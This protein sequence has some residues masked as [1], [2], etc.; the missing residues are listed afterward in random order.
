MGIDLCE[1]EECMHAFRVH[2]CRYLCTRNLTSMTSGTRLKGEDDE[3]ENTRHPMSA[4][5]NGDQ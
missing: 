5:S 1:R 2:S 3:G 4:V